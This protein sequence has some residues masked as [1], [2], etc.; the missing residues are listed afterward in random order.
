MKRAWISSKILAIGLAVCVVAVSSWAVLKRGTE[1]KARLHS[2]AADVLSVLPRST[3]STLTDQTIA[4]WADRVRREPKEDRSWANLGDALMQKAR[5]TADAA[6]YGHAQAAYQQALQLN[7]KSEAALIGLAWV[8]GGRHE[9]EQSIAWADRALA[10]DQKNNDAYG[11]LGD[12]DIEIGDYPAAFAHYQKMLDLRPD[13]ASYSRGAHLLWLNGNFR[14]AVWLMV[15]AVETGAPY[16]ENTAWCR[17]QLG[18]MLYS[19]GALVPAEQTLKAGL[20]LAPANW[21]LLAAMG[22]VKTAE[23]DYPAAID[24]Y[25]RSIAVVPQHDSLVALGDLYR[26]TGR[27]QEAEQ[28]YGLVET[29]DKLNKANGVRGGWQ[30][31]LFLADHDRNPVEALKQAQAEYATRKNVYAADTLAWCLYQNGRY[32][33]AMEAIRTALSKHTPEALFQFHA[34]MIAAKLGDRPTAQICLYRAMS[35]NPHFSP[36]YA[37]M[38]ADALKRLGETPPDT[39]QT[40]QR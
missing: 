29:I 28:Q 21:R 4:K 9:F 10:L 24:Y 37:T 35:L 26:L 8:N 31:A 25:K 2:T 22:K 7:P 11:L 30:M 39:E 19:N 33:E 16:A 20:K 1:G 32:A 36:V 13:I 5:E 15:K 3:G 27:P 6:Y 38:A 18:L 23:K 17:A 12:A 14:K 34:G 40:A